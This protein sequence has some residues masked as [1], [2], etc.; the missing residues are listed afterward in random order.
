MSTQAQIIA[1]RIN[2]QKSCGPKTEA[3]KQ[4]S[5]QNST[6][7]GL[8]DPNDSFTI[9]HYENQDEFIQFKLRLYREQNP[10]DETE[11][12]LV[13][14]MLE[15]EWLRRRAVFLQ[16]LCQNKDGFLEQE[17]HFALYMRYQTTHERGFYRALNELQKIRNE[18]R[19]EQIGFVSQERAKAADYRAAAA[20]NLKK[21]EFQLKKQRADGPQPPE[22][23]VTPPNTPVPNPETSPGGLEMAA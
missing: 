16:T 13:R 19:K 17:K 6:I 18:R 14:R 2:A 8:A 10:Q 12:I 23:P 1:N 22:K 9:A 11:C 3:G 4:A 15:S 7:H 5:S 21:L 20:L